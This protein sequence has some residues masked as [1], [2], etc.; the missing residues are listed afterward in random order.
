MK[1][2]VNE[3]V[4]ADAVASTIWSFYCRRYYYYCC[5]CRQQHRN[6]D[7]DFEKPA[8]TFSWA[9]TKFPPRWKRNRNLV[10]YIPGNSFRKYNKLMNLTK[11]SE[12]NKKKKN[13]NDKISF[14]F[15]L[16][17]NLSRIYQIL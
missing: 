13:K 3:F 10:Y 15:S 8:P 7:N 2:K 14:F 4:S 9:Q 16:F 5:R 1:K 11:N 17:W 12:S 6:D